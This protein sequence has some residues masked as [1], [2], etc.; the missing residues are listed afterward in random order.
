[1]TFWTKKTVVKNRPV[2]AQLNGGDYEGGDMQK[3]VIQ[4][5]GS[6]SQF[7]ILVVL[8]VAKI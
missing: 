8:M 2:A 1:M 3:G 6:V 7:H 4:G 5:G